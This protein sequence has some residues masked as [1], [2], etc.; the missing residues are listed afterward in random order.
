MTVAVRCGPKEP[1][2]VSVAVTVADMLLLLSDQV[3]SA[4]TYD[5]ARQPTMDKSRSA[6]VQHWVKCTTHCLLILE[7]HAPWT[8]PSCS[9]TPPRTSTSQRYLPCCPVYD[10]TLDTLVYWR[11]APCKR[12]LSSRGPES[13]AESDKLLLPCMPHFPTM[14]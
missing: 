1:K 9:I 5:P 11:S 10:L 4:H 14:W 8:C 3:K 7:S 6:R 12:E 2:T 13:H